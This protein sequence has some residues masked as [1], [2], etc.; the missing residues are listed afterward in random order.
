MSEKE[1]I[2]VLKVLAYFSFFCLLLFDEVGVV[3]GVGVGVIDAA[4][5]SEEATDDDPGVRLLSANVE[6]CEW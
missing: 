5:D 3:M 2:T 1:I 6:D 4:D